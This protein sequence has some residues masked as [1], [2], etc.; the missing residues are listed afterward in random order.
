MSVPRTRLRSLV[1][2]VCLM[3]LTILST[4]GQ[5]EPA[6]RSVILMIGDGMGPHQVRL[7]AAYKGDS[8]VMETLPVQA[9]LSTR[10]ASH[11]VT[12]SAAAATALATGYKT[13][14][15]MIGVTPDGLPK[16]TILEAAKE[17]G[18][19]TGTI[20]TTHPAHATPAA[21]VAHVKSRTEYTEI[22]AQAL[23]AGQSIIMG[24]GAAYFLP[25][26]LG[27]KRTDGRHLLEEAQERGYRVVSDH[28]ELATL[29]PQLVLGLFGGVGSAAMTYTFDRRPTTTEPSIADMTKA[30]LGVLSHAPSGFFLMVEAGRIDTACH[31]NDAL[32]SIGETLAFDEAV[33]VAV[34]YV[35][36]HPD[37]LLVVTAD[38]ETGGLQLEAKVNGEVLRGLKSS[39]NRLVSQVVANPSGAESLL[40]KHAGLG[41]LSSLERSLLRTAT[42]NKAVRAAVH[43]IIGKRG[44]FHWS[45]A[46]HTA[47]DVPL[48]ALGARATAF[49]G[50]VYSNTEVP[51]RLA[52]IMGLELSEPP[53]E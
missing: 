34:A 24:A 15:G 19:A 16:K 48:Y 17:A 26:D 53:K 3:L 20:T 28:R 7:A 52:K 43:E 6:V 46:G 30:A 11:A 50:G 9:A 25:E 49:E 1:L 22:A 35:N 23:N 38:H 8:L 13:N 44:G 5:A 51:K 31:D 10:A 21:F 47:T 41:S 2:F 29:A 18:R 39:I 42:G 36:Q 37:T 45:T 14:N 33:A 27:G 4:A 12:D 40:R 32:Y